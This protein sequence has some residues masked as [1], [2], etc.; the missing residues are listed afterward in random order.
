MPPKVAYV[1]AKALK[2]ESHLIRNK[3]YYEPVGQEIALIEAHRNG[4]RPFCITIDSEARD[5]LPHKVAD[6][7]R[8]LTT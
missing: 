3:P 4:I 6:I 2:P 8:R 5:N 1:Q 7:Y